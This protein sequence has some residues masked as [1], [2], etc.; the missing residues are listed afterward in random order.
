M[1]PMEYKMLISNHYICLK[2]VFSNRNFLII[3]TLIRVMLLVMMMK[4]ICTHSNPLLFLWNRISL[5]S[6]SWSSTHNPPATIPSYIKYSWLTVTSFSFFITSSHFFLAC[7][8]SADKFS[9]SCVQSHCVWY[10]SFPI[11]SFVFVFH[12]D[13]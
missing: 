3:L 1:L 6:P 9:G 10:A 13:T 4:I 8:V 2:W 7:D 11:H 5:C 12:L